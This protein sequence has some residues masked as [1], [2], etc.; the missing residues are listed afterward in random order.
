MLRGII[1]LAV[2][3]IATA[4]RA[5]PLP[6]RAGLWCLNTTVNPQQWQ[7]CSVT[8]PVPVAP[9][10]PTPSNSSAPLAVTIASPLPGACPANPISKKVPPLC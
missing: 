9:Q 1:A 7:P 4:A 8:N 3:A 2:V 6:D 5:Q 10:N